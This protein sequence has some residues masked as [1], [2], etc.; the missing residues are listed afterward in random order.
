MANP[1]KVA[2]RGKGLL[3]LRKRAF[4]IS[5]R[6]GLTAAKMNQSLNLFNQILKQFNCGASLAITAVVLER[7]PDIIAKYL[8]QNI[9]FIVHG[10]T[11]IDYSQ[12][13][14][15]EQLAHL[16][17]A[18]QIFSA[19]GIAVAGF[20]SP[21]LRREPHLYAAIET[22]GFSYASNQPVWWPVIDSNNLTPSVR[23][24]YERALSFYAPW[25]AGKQPSLPRFHG[26]IVEIPV[27]L[28]D[29]EILIDRL[30]GASNNLVERVWQ[31][32]LAKSYQRGELFTIQ[33]HPERIRE[34]Q[35][36]LGATLVEAR[37]LTPSVWIARLDEIAA[38]W[39]KRATAQ[40]DVR[41]T[42]TDT[43]RLSVT[44]PPGL[45]ILAR[46]VEICEP[47]KPWADNYQQVSGTTCHIQ[48]DGR[49]FIGVSPASPPAL[50]NFLRQQGYLVEINDNSHLY[51]IY[52]DRRDFTPQNELP[53]GT[54]V[55]DNAAQL[56]RL[57]RWPN[58]ARS[59]LSI[60]GDIDA[61]T[62]GDY[63]L[64]LFEK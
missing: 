2:T 15:P 12:L 44:G 60:T 63:A 1:F 58:G 39:H 13:A 24:S 48:T 27:S 20:R 50:V 16:H 17:H 33:L 51:P 4:T 7:N 11:H 3:A 64:R 10:Y 45:T 55:E 42:G 62:L 41:E 28:P 31:A 8:A 34:C 21:Y 9:E 23:T 5:R 32:I 46:G 54:Y 18:R 56:V 57:A 43:L 59:A 53:L 25:R 38:W 47:T 40:I 36:G 35:Q 22:V 49:P 52:L 61:L 26:S 6:Y 30:D 37:R 19:A 29:D 14:P